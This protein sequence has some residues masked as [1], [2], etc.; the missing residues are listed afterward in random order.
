M[1]T[2]AEELVAILSDEGVS[3]L[4]VN[5][6]MYTA[7]LRQALGEAGAKGVPHPEAVLC[8]HEHIAVCAAH[9]HHLAGG[10][11]QAVMVHVESGELSLSGAVKNAQRDRIPMALFVGD[12]AECR[13]LLTPLAGLRH[14]SSPTLINS[15][16]KWGADL[17]EEGDVG[18]LTRRAFQIAR[19]PPAGLTHLALP[20]DRLRQPAGF[21]SRRLPPPRLPAPDIAALEDVAELLASAEWPLIIAGRVG[22][23]IE[24]VHHL[25]RLAETLGAPVIDVRNHVNLPR[26]HPLNA[27]LDGRELFDRADAVLL[28]DVETPCVPVLG[29]PPA[30][31][32][33]LQIDT[34]CLK[35]DVPGWTYPIEVA[36]TADT[37]SAL[38][39]LL[40]L[41]NNRLGGRHRRLHDRRKRV[42]KELRA[43]R[44]SW[45]DRAAGGAPA[46]RS[47]AVLAE[48][49][50]CLPEDA[51]I[52]EEV[53]P[54]LRGP[55]RQLDRLPGHLFRTNAQSPGWA[56]GA[57]L[58]A[59]LARPSQPVVAICDE[60]AFVAGL[61]TAAF[62][63]AHRGGAPFL[64]VVL[65]Q[66]RLR[67]P[68]PT[69][70]PQLD[71]ASV[72]RDSGAEAIVIDRARAVAE[73]VERLLAT[74]RD[75]DCAVLDVQLPVGAAEEPYVRPNRRRAGLT[76]GSTVT[77]RQLA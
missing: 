69:R 39:P 28:L 76:T 74:T 16:G 10:G 29:P 9:G 46:D 5:P 60:T 53:I 59:R 24:S 41:L 14:P 71:V 64:T 43:L 54:G 2:A 66:G 31:A 49:Q 3:H 68:R 20:V 35:A 67:A 1:R 45:R 38:P 23:N 17:S 26:S 73:A 55:H 13:T 37:Q 36:V 48:L 30:Q 77:K 72:A 65:D 19:T 75:G 6:G 52:V 61:P 32:W 47:D 50:R 15:I 33:L 11:P 4:F 70:E 62:W 57:A 8:V 63:S 34:D 58:G 25:A 7:P 21:A 22:R 12:S 42:E 56:L 18:T 51:V 40:A 27:G 44:E